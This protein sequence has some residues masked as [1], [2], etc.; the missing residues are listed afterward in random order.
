MSGDEGIVLLAGGFLAVWTW[1]GWYIPAVAVERLSAPTPGRLAI[2]WTPALCAGLLFAVLKL[3]ASHDVRDDPVYLVFYLTMGAAWVGVAM[4][5]LPYVGLSARD[6][7]VERGNPAG[8]A[9]VLGALVA[10]TCCFAGGNIGDGPGW[11]VVVCAAGLATGVLA[12]LWLALDALCRVS[13]TI[14]VERDLAAGLR[15]AGLF[16]GAGLVLGRAVAGDWI[17]LSATLRDFVV[18][19][20]PVV[21]LFAV[22]A[23]IERAA[24]PT[25][26]RPSQPVVGL[27][28][29]PGIVY[30]AAATAYVAWL[31]LPS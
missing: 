21:P 24:V 15:C 31:G 26:V 16:V 8:A 18:V 27:G 5:L 11:W 4:K 7:A 10:V 22:A 13:D 23:A 1:Y 3:L 6:D 20:W 25:P 17:S 12:G 19:G 2:L 9:A 14:T 30:L 29:L 28:L